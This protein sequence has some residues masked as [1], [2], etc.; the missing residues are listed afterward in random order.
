MVAHAPGWM[1]EAFGMEGLVKEGLV[2][3]HDEGKEGNK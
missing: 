3:V 2:I 1:V